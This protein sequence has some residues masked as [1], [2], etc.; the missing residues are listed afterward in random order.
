VRFAIENVRIG[1]PEGVQEAVELLLGAAVVRGKFV[2]TSM[3]MKVRRVVLVAF[4]IFAAGP[5][6]QAS[7]DAWPQ[8]IE[9]LT[10]GT[11]EK[12]ATANDDE[13]QGQETAPPGR[14]EQGD[15]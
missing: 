14:S 12:P 9:T 11:H 5:T 1:G 7:L 3:A 10:P 8:V 4:A 2:P 13:R 15:Q 6:V